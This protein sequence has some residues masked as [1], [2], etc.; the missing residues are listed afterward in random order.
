MVRRPDHPMT[1]ATTIWKRLETLF[2]ADAEALRHT[3]W[4]SVYGR[5][6]IWLA[7]VAMLARRSDT[8][9]PEQIEFIYLN[10]SLAA[11]NGFVHWRLVRS[12]TVTWRWMV[13]LSA[14]DIALITANV[15]VNAAATGNFDNLVFIAYYPSLAIFAV[16]FSSFRLVMVWVTM[17]AVVYAV[18]SM[19][20]GPGTNFSAVQDNVLLAR[21][22]VMYLVAAGVN[23][24]ARF[25]RDRR[26]A[27]MA[28]ERRLQQERIELS[29]TI[30]DT[31]AQTAYLIGIGIENARKL[32][33]DSNQE[34]AER[35]AA[36][37]VLSKSAIWE[38]RGPIDMGRIFAGRELGGALSAHAS[39]FAR[40]TSVPTELVQSGEEPP[41][42][43]AVRTGFFSIAHNALTNALLHAQAAR[44]EVRL[45]FE[46][47][48]VRLSVSD[49]GVGLPENYA[50]R[51]RGFHGM[52]SQAERMGGTL[53]AE[54][55]GTTGGTTITCFVPHES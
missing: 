24:I 36:T 55:G 44:V 47:R 43:M 48:G 1:N 35:L 4:I 22:F 21:L 12:E 41:L 5:W 34:L 54:S 9:Y 45:A 20:A 17:T 18:V 46:D 15:A 39:T 6:F 32:A 31:A 37:A 10:V 28:R 30:H 26:N 3:L 25:E 51:G 27:L 38:L 19:S 16:V 23:L 52:E 42:S 2:E 49:D 13:A 11:I 53:V 50:R 40:I 33:G 8:W 29:Q 7:A 14:A